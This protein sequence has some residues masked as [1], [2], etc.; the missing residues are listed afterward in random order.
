MT[1]RTQCLDGL[2]HVGQRRGHECRQTDQVHILAD[3]G[4]DYGLNGYV[5]SQIDDAIAVILYNSF[6]DILTDI[7][8]ISLYRRNDDLTLGNRSGSLLGHLGADD[9]KGLLCCACRV[10]ELGQEDFSALKASADHVQCWNEQFIDNI[11]FRLARRKQIDSQT[12]CFVLESLLN[13]TRQRGFL[14]L[15]SYRLYRCCRLTGICCNVCFSVL[16]SVVQDIECADGVH[17]RRGIGIYDRQIQTVRQRKRQ[18]TGGNQTAIGQT[19]RNIGH[20]KCAVQTQ[21]VTHHL[22]SS[23][24]LD[25]LVLL[26]RYGERQ[27]V[28]EHVF[29]GN[30]V[31][32]RCV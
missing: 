10:D 4:L 18:E 9:L 24:G 20:A 26:S 31:G 8:N 23:Q 13:R 28:D 16:V 25:R 32:Q 14:S 1:A 15:R 22:H 2:I 27:A 6:H 17:D 21:T 12:A 7:V 19:K 11:Q 3:G 5:T 30:T 29:L